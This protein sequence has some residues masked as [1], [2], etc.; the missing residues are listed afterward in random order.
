MV[1]AYVIPHLAHAVTTTSRL[2]GRFRHSFWAEVYETVLATYI[3]I[4]TTLAMLSPKLGKFNVTS[5]GGLIDRDHFDAKI[6]RPYVIL[7][8]LNLTGMAFGAWRLWEGLDQDDAVIINLFWAAYNLVVLGAALAVAWEARQRR[9]TSRIDVRLPA[10][11]RRQSGHTYVGETM[12]LSLG[13]AQLGLTGS[14]ELEPGEEVHL[15]LFLDEEE[16]TI[17]GTVVS[18]DAAQVRLDFQDLDL[19]EESGLARSIYSRAD[20]WD[21]WHDRLERDRPLRSYLRIIGHSVT[22]IPRFLLGRSGGGA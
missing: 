12:D 2:Q 4:P 1:L 5:K 7:L 3:M 17:H 16:V 11:L 10:M 21:G 18:P 22:A 9:R 14:P 19:Q 20:A 13:G 15:T 8:L 6:A